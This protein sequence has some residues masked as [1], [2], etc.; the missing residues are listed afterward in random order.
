VGYGAAILAALVLGVCVRPLF[1]GPIDNDG[2]RQELRLEHALRLEGQG[3]AR[4]G[5]DRPT[6]L[7]ADMQAVEDQPHRSRHTSPFDLNVIGGD[8][9]PAARRRDLLG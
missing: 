3:N 7:V 6:A 9:H 8:S 5:G 2:R 1:F 4:C